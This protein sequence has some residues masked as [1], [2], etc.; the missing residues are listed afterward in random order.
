MP[1]LERELWELSNIRT[2]H[3]GHGWR[4][5]LCLR[6]RK[7]NDRKKECDKE[8]GVFFRDTKNVSKLMEPRGMGQISMTVICL[9]PQIYFSLPHRSGRLDQH[10]VKKGTDRI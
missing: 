5:Q 2:S 8:M 4:E 3:L 6:N 9:A 7:R 1:N 10:Q